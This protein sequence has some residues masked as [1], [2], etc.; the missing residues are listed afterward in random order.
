MCRDS[1][2][3]NHPLAPLSGITVDER[4]KEIAARFAAHG[5]GLS[6]ADL[7]GATLAD[8]DLRR[9][10]RTMAITMNGVRNER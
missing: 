6:G 8:A 10:D 7:S 1:N 3:Q 9:G 4:L 5:L 2:V